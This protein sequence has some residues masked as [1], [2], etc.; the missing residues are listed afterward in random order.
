VLGLYDHG[1][2]LGLN[3]AL[4]LETAHVANGP[5][6]DADA[7]AAAGRATAVRQRPVK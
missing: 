1:T 3:A 4:A 2:D 6:W 5:A 7:F